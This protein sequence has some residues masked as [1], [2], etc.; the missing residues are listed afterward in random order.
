MWRLTIN[1]RQTSQAPKS[2][3]EHVPHNGTVWCVTV[4]NGTLL[5][6]RGGKPVVTLN[7][8]RFMSVVEGTALGGEAKI[9]LSFGWLGDVEQIDYMTRAKARASWALGFGVAE[10]EITTGHMY[11]TPVPILPDYSCALHGKI[12]R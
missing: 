8:H 10:H 12:Y 7:T 6:R 2:S 4:P 1:E 3:W 9:A 5:V 11:F